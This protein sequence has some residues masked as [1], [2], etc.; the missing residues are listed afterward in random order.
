VF[1]PDYGSP[2]YLTEFNDL[3][4]RVNDEPDFELSPAEIQT[5]LKGM[6]ARIPLNG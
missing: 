4:R 3:V 6:L 2:S 5:A 1:N